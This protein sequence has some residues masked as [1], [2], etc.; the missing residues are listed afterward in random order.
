MLTEPLT[1][2][3]PS[4]LIESIPSMLLVFDRD[5]RFLSCNAAGASAL[6]LGGEVT[7]DRV[8]ELLGADLTAAVAA[9]VAQAQAVR[10]DETAVLVGASRRVFGFTLSPIRSDGQV[11]AALATGRDITERVEI[12][13]EVEELE[14]RGGLARVARKVAHELRNPLNAIRVYAQYT[15]MALP[16][17]DPARSYA[18]VIMDEVDRL[19]RVLRGLHDLSHA[20]QLELSLASPETA[21]RHACR[22]AVPLTE[23]A[24]VRFR[25]EIAPELPPVLHDPHR[26][27]QVALNLVKNAVEATPPGGEV[28]FRAFAEPGPSLVFQVDDEGPGVDPAVAERLFELFVT[29][30]QGRGEGIGLTVCREIVEEHGGTISFAPRPGGGTRFRVE[31]HPR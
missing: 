5:A 10:V 7:A 22:L 30:K 23:A 4:A 21:L 25:E 19:D 14:R 13:Q 31:L 9:C 6:G 2:I 16:A 26:L 29:T 11:V 8:A 17:H 18:E 1:G 27:G 3:T 28:A 24:A 20:H 15:A 12:Q